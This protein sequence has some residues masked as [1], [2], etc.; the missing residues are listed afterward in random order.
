MVFYRAYTFQPPGDFDEN[1][2][3][4]ALE[5]KLKSPGDSNVCQN[6]DSPLLDFANLFKEIYMPAKGICHQRKRDGQSCG[7]LKRRSSFYCLQLTAVAL[8]GTEAKKKQQ[9]GG[10]VG[11][12]SP[13]G[14]RHQCLA[15]KIATKL[16][17]IG[18]VNSE[19]WEK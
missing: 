16:I 5:S 2:C 9:Q 3:A 4:Y 17:Y 8:G 13:M 12:H 15:F 18:Q 1:S 7:I 11:N 19:L 14:E 10:G 6:L